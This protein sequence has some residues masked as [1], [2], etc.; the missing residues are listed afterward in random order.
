MKPMRIMKGTAA[1]L[2]LMAA[3]IP[4][5]QAQIT[6]PTV[7]VGNAGNPNDPAT[8]DLYG[9]VDHVYDIGTYEVTLD[10]Y[11]AFL[12]AVAV[13]DTYGL[14]NSNMATSGN[15]S[16]IQQSGTSGSFTYSV[17][18]PSGIAPAGASSPGGRPVTWVSWFDAVRFANW[19]ANGQPTGVG[20]VDASTEDGAYALHGA[21]SGVDITKNAINPNTSAAP[22]WWIPSESEWYK[23]AYYDPTP[24]AGGG[25]NYWVY[26]TRTND[27]PGNT[28]GGQP[29]QA[30]FENSAGNFAVTQS[31]SYDPNQNYL[32]DSGAFSD[33]ASYYGTFDQGGNVWEW[34]YAIIEETG[35][36][37][38]GGSWAYSVGDLESYSRWGALPE[39]ENGSIGFRVATVPEP[40][41]V[42]L[43]LLGGGA[44]GLWRRRKAAC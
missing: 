30:N 16:G 23:A 33:S 1:A 25:S 31:G 15:V 9:A 2:G 24:G 11:A 29:N 5:G 37:L 13:T 35:R 42:L 38:R 44:C 12:N 41:T 10:Q 19:M 32:T 43:V 20:Q 14:Y 22:T 3:G 8:G 26:P 7:T 40:S 21:T 18:G 36:G 17:I 34:N 6:I 39:S 4:A 28:I 27:E